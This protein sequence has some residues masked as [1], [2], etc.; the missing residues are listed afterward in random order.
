MEEE[1]DV[2][3]EVDGRGSEHGCRTGGGARGRQGRR[4][5]G[6]ENG[7]N[8]GS[9]VG[10]SEHE[11]AREGDS[12]KDN[13]MASGEEDHSPSS[14]GEMVPEATVSDDSNINP[15]VTVSDRPSRR[16]QMPS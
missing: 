14:S 6:R 5:G 12:D 3:G 7:D 15:S 10:S 2:E 8:N 4:G 13:A 9:E 11:I 16:R 1:E